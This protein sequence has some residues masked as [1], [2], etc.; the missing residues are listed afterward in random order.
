MKKSTWI[1]GGLQ[2]IGIG[3]KHNE[4]MWDFYRTQFN[5][6]ISMFD[7]IG[8]A[9]VMAPYMGNRVWERHAVFAIN[10]NGGAGMEFWQYTNRNPVGLS[11][12]ITLGHFGILATY[13]RCKNIH[14]I[15]EH[16]LHQ[17]IEVSQISYAPDGSARC[18]V[19]DI[20]SNWICLVETNEGWFLLPKT[21]NAI[22]YGGVCG[23][24][25][26]VS[27]MDK[28]IEF[29][30]TICGYDEIVYD[31]TDAFSDFDV[32]NGQQEVRRVGLCRSSPNRG[33]FAPLLSQSILELV[34]AKKK[35][36]SHVFKNRYW[37]DIGFIHL[38]F[39]MRGMDEF[40]Q[41]CAD[42][43]YPFTIDT[44]EEFSMD[45]ASGRF[46]YLE[47]PDG[48][49]IEFVEVFKMPILPKYGIVLDITKRA[50]GK[51][52]PSF[53]IKALRYRKKTY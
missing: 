34:E 26:G 43:D 22:H 4:L 3:V 12:E 8:S 11:Q 42:R 45:D 37:G 38:C 5:F 53:M 17:N 18:F 44:G 13:I 23:A 9:D 6:D 30:K 15:Y 51:P 41:Y 49:L 50:M 24:L 14:K 36:L 32:L 39:D 1:N 48:T 40:K 27:C 21:H 29:Y 28:S 31:E 16:L 35:K 7:E 33:T 2:Q 19:R 46:A 20:E 10:L 47:D 25:V 52:L